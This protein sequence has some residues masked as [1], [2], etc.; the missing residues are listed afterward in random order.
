MTEAKS[1]Q[2]NPIDIRALS[3]GTASVALPWRKPSDPSSPYTQSDA[4]HWEHP[5]SPHRRSM[6]DDPPDVATFLAHVMAGS[7][8]G[9][10]KPPAD[11]RIVRM[12]RFD[13]AR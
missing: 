12:N 7:G 3:I 4:K 11:S 9:L 10:N 2:V 6:F 1:R 13:Q 8:M 5:R